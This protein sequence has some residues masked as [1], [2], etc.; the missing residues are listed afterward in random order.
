MKK[1]KDIKIGIYKITNKIN[2]KVYIGQSINIYSRWYAHKSMGKPN[3]IYSYKPLYR[4]M[5][6]YGIKNFAFDIIEECC[7]ELLNEKEQYYISLYNSMTPNGYN[8]DSGGSDNRVIC[9]E[10]RQRLSEQR[11]G[12]N[13]A[14][15][16][17]NHSEETKKNL[18]LNAQCKQYSNE[19]KD[20]LKLKRRL[21]KTYGSRKVKSNDG[22]VWG[23]LDDCCYELKIP[24]T[25][26][27]ILNG[28]RGRTK[29]VDEYGLEYANEEDVVTQ[30]ILEDKVEEIKINST[31]KPIIDVY[32]NIFRTL[33]VCSNFYNTNIKVD[34]KTQTIKTF[35]K[36]NYLKLRLL[37]EEEK[38]TYKDFLLDY[39]TNIRVRKVIDKDGRIFD[40]IDECSKYYDIP[41]LIRYLN[42]LKPMPEE[43]KKYG[44]RYLSDKC[45]IIKQPS[46]Y[47]DIINI[48][49]KIIFPT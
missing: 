37:T 22:R 20:K 1:Y 14:M 49:G 29:I 12:E 48:N 7:K 31:L 16:G 8:C 17:K 45:E 33:R 32:G 28:K 35:I 21:N 41:W 18:S 2:G 40:S 27:S 23:S 44:I 46:K 30:V 43:Y 42:N 5:I 15:Y 3:S 47:G 9:E 34:N 4:S 25:L 24:S 38:E 11:S 36:Y 13:N 19:T 10:T 6:K 26:Y 39:S